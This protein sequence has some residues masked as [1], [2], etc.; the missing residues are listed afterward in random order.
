MNLKLYQMAL[1]LQGDIETYLRSYPEDYELTEH[2]KINKV[3]WCNEYN[4]LKVDY[5]DTDLYYFDNT[6]A[7]FK[8][9]FTTFIGELVGQK[10]LRSCT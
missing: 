6:P 9:K 1:I 8:V 4:M 10:L 7:W 3:E 2:I 5:G